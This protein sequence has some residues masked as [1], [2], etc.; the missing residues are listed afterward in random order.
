MR[1]YKTPPGHCGENYESVCC[2]AAGPVAETGEQEAGGRA[3]P[4]DLACS[5][6]YPEADPTPYRYRPGS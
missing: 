1:L 5:G 2:G 4:E 3:D 6:S